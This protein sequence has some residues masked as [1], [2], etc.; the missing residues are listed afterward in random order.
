MTNLEVGEAVLEAAIRVLAA[1]T[2]KGGDF[3]AKIGELVASFRDVYEQ[4]TEADDL[5]R[6]LESLDI[7]SSLPEDLCIMANLKALEIVRHALC[8]ASISRLEPSLI[9][10]LDAVVIPSVNSPFAAIQ[11][12]G[13]RC[14]GLY[15]TISKVCSALHFFPAQ[16]LATEYMP[17][18]VD[19]FLLG[20]GEVRATSLQ[21]LFDWFTLHGIS[22]DS[23]SSARKSPLD[24]AIRSLYDPDPAIQCIS[25]EG[26][27]RL[28]LH[29]VHR[30][31]QIL[32]GLLHLY[33]HPSTE[34]Q[35]R[36]RQ[37]LSY[38]LP[39]FALSAVDNQQ[40]MRQVVPSVLHTWMGTVKTIDGALPLSSVAAQLLHFSD[41]SNLI[42]E[43]QEANPFAALGMHR[44][45]MLCRLCIGVELC[46]RALSD[47]TES[48]LC[49]IIAKLPVDASCP[50]LRR[51]FYLLGVLMR[52]NG[53]AALKKFVGLLV[54]LGG[55]EALPAEEVAA[56]QERVKRA[57]PLGMSTLPT[58]TAP[59]AV[60]QRK[61][62]GRPRKPANVGNIL[63]E[64]ENF[65]DDGLE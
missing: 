19:F 42:V 48:P 15:G 44:P 50:E 12:A 7:N 14:L 25:A 13:L 59:A 64:L 22:N 62:Q 9:A 41:P 53:N 5:H 28:L 43:H 58:T 20:Q 31:P 39:A 17:L 63:D 51:L 21:S 61:P 38:F 8:V 27:S 34:A 45:A 1:V 37:C 29:R 10:L 65:D 60:S 30:D 11:A 56:L 23:S 4:P 26:F 40:L 49:A 3:M 35:P 18:M 2:T 47:P 32:E 33:F 55:S 24:T 57:L 16:E 52:F 46:W 6:S 36:L 54:E